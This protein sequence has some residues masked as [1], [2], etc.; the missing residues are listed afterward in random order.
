MSFTNDQEDKVEKIQGYKTLDESIPDLK[1]FQDW[2]YKTHLKLH[3]RIIKNICSRCEER[4]D[5]E[6]CFECYVELKKEFEQKLE[7]EKTIEKIKMYQQKMEE[8][9]KAAG[10]PEEIINMGA[11]CDENQLLELF[12]NCGKEI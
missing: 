7:D 9:C 6:L 5:E 4:C 11:T 3:P 12:K 2:V 8:I 1:D 10:I